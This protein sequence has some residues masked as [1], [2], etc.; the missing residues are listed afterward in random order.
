MIDNIVKNMSCKH[1]A[2]ILHISFLEFLDIKLN[3][4]HKKYQ[5]N[6]I[7]IKKHK[8]TIYI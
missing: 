8:S 1:Q 6:F 7:I 5:L 4:L 2:E 3:T